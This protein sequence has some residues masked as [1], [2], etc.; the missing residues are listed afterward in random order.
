M[1][2]F[3]IAPS[4]S[5]GHYGFSI[6]RLQFIVIL[7]LNNITLPLDLRDIEVALLSDGVKSGSSRFGS[8]SMCHLTLSFVN[9][10]THSTCSVLGNMSTGWTRSAAYPA[11]VKR[12]R[13][14]ARVAGSQET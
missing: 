8:T 7:S 5:S 11:S 2:A 14:R 12:R 9:P 6:L 4:F 1:S 13:S 3:I 10:T